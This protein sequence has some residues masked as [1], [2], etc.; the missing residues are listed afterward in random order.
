MPQVLALVMFIW[1]GF[2][3]IVSRGNEEQIE[4]GKKNDLGNAR[5]CGRYVKLCVCECVP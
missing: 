5:H 3:W 1:G 4:V 2:D